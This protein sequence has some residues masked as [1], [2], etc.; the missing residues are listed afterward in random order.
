VLKHVLK[1]LNDP[2]PLHRTLGI[3]PIGQT[4]IGPSRQNREPVMSILL[5]LLGHLC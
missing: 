4:A 1:L 3:E 2:K 5:Q